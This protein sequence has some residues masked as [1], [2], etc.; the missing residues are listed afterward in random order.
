MLKRSILASVLLLI[1]LCGTVGCKEQPAEMGRLSGDQVIMADGRSV[2]VSLTDKGNQW[3]TYADENGYAYGIDEQGI[4][5]YYNAIAIKPHSKEKI[6]EEQAKAIAFKHM[7]ETYGKKFLNGYTLTECSDRGMD[8]LLYYF[9]LYGEEQMIKGEMC[10]VNVDYF[11]KVGTSSIARK[12]FKDFD[13]T[14]LKGITKETLTEYARAQGTAQKPN[15]TFTG[16]GDVYLYKSD[17][18][19]ALH[20]FIDMELPEGWCNHTECYYPLQ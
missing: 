16:L 11:G 4:L 3:D 14:L 20:L 2:A 6:T 15:S 12:T 17:T 19:Y 5:V 10:H 9:K 1:F 8:Y 7:V 13:E 18:G